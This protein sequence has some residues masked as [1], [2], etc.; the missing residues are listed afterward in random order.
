MPFEDDGIFSESGFGKISGS[1]CV[2]DIHVLNK[3]LVPEKKKEPLENS[4]F[5]RG[6]WCARRDLNPHARSE[7]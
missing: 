7:H 1:R 3:E 5:S 6:L 4:V 2:Q